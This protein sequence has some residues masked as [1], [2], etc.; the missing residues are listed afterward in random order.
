MSHE[1]A[2]DS[3]EVVEL[4]GNMYGGNMYGGNM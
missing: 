1:Y 3:N 2:G 4:G